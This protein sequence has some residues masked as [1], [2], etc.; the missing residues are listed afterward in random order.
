MKPTGP[1]NSPDKTGPL[2]QNVMVEVAFTFSLEIDIV[3]A[4]DTEITTLTVPLTMSSGCIA[5]TGESVV[6]ARWDEPDGGK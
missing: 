5:D 4:D 3:S 1:P 6:C 2:T